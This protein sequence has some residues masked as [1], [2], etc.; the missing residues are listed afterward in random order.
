MGGVANADSLTADA[1]RARLRDVRALLQNARTASPAQRAPLLDSARSLLR[2]TTDIQIAGGSLAIDDSALASRITDDTVA[3]EISEL[4]RYIALVDA[5]LA[6][7][8]DAERADA[9]LRQLTSGR[10]VAADLSAILAALADRFGRWLYDALG[11]P[12]PS[13]VFDAQAVVGTLLAI[14]VVALLVRGVRERIRRETT[15]T[16]ET[17]GERTDPAA[18]LRRA[19][20]ALRGGAP[21]DAIHHLYLYALMTLAARQVIRYDPALT[22][23][24]LVRRAASIPHA[25]ALSDLVQLHERVWFGLRDARDPDVARA[26]SL[27]V[28]VAA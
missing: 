5:A 19:D 22:D 13:W 3:Q 26:R 6:R 23:H 25:E 4:D 2:S 21:R 27:A 7:R 12:D 20:E 24:E 17:A 9:T 11:R 15:V 16:S 28:L 1:Y 14:T 10:S 18:H 8:I